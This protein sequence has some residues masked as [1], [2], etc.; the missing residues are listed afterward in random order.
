MATFTLVDVMQRRGDNPVDRKVVDEVVAAAPLFNAMPVRVIKGTEYKYMK[1]TSVPTIGARPANAGATMLKSAYE[2]HNAQAF[3]Y[4]GLIYVDSMVAKADPDGKNALMAEEMK[5]HLRGAMVG[6]EQGLIYGKAKDEF[7]MYG[8][9]NLIADYMT[10][11]ANSSL[12]TVQGGSSVWMLNLS[13]DY[14]HLLFGNDKTLGFGPEVETELSRPTGR[15]LADGTAEMGLMRAHSRHLETW[16]GFALK[17]IWAAG[18]I[19]NESAANPLTDAMLAKM[20]RNFPTGHKPTHLVMNQA[21]LARW[22]QSR[23]NALTFVKSGKNANGGVIADEPTEFRGLKVIVTDSL[24][25]DET[26]ANIA[27]LKNKLSI[28]AED[29]LDKVGM[30]VNTNKPQ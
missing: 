3:A 22:E 2:T 19:C 14:Q 12:T 4:D 26:A 30:L 9:V 6:W 21:T 25:E 11:S 29:Y 27:A 28:D 15:V 18:R 8:L 13:E 10:M 1:R 16:M 5:N 20:L 24:L 23:T 7:G 17:N